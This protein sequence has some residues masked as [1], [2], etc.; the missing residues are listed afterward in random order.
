MAKCDES[1]ERRSDGG[2]GSRESS[3][4][5]ACTRP[6]TIADLCCHMSGFIISIRKSQD[7][8]IKMPSGRI[9]WR[10]RHFLRPDSTTAAP[11]PTTIPT[12]PTET[13]ETQQ[14]NEMP[15]SASKEKHHQTA[16][17]QQN[18]LVVV[19][20]GRHRSTVII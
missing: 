18:R 16:K 13:G 12:T 4:L 17:S 6:E 10:N 8:R 2:E 15:G 9:Y 19:L 7:C 3:V 14:G 11:S 1:K 20:V 5:Q